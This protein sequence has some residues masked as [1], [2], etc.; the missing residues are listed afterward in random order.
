MWVARG[1]E[2]VQPW[3]ARP[4]RWRVERLG[5]RGVEARVAR[6]ERR[7]G[8]RVARGGGWR[9]EDLGRR[10]RQRRRRGAAWGGAD[11]GQP[12]DVVF[13]PASARVP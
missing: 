4:W 11:V 2:V 6:A 5:R 8:A 7:G 1:G 13:A 12:D 10:E 9:V 3:R